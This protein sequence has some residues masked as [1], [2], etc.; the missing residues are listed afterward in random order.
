MESIL[1]YVID[2]VL[3]IGSI[4]VALVAFCAIFALSKFD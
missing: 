4:A 1:Y 3:G 2:V